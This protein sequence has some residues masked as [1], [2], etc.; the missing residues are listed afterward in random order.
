M[1]FGWSLVCVVRP[2]ADRADKF[3]LCPYPGAMR[4]RY[5]GDMARAGRGMG[6]YAGALTAGRVVRFIAPR[7]G[8][9]CTLES[10]KPLR[11]VTRKGLCVP[12][13]GG[14]HHAIGHEAGRTYLLSRAWAVEVCG[15]L[16]CLARSVGRMPPG[17]CRG[18]LPC[19]RVHGIRMRRHPAPRRERVNPQRIESAMSPVEDRARRVNRV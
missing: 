12:V 8:M 3:G 18:S 11:A 15:R 14:G 17:K 19:K 6:R 10:A 13:T 5:I 1:E 7:W 4:R 2:F 16:G 9:P